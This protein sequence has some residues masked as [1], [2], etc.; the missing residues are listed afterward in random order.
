MDVICKD[1]TWKYSLIT[2]FFVTIKQI[3]MFKTLIRLLGNFYNFFF[4]TYNH[5]GKK[6]RIKILFLL[7]EIDRDKKNPFVEE[8]FCFG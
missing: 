5:V 2:L 8:Y 1:L 3:Y 6:K 4:L 7:K